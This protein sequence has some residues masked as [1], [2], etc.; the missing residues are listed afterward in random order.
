[1]KITKIVPREIAITIEL[2]LTESEA[3]L[4]ALNAAQIVCSEEADKAIN[5]FFN[6]LN[7]AVKAAKGE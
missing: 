7:G 3:V 6:V 1:M 4:D 5:E 2:T